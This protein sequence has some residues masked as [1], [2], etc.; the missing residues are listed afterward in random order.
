[1][2][3]TAAA[4]FLAKRMIRKPITAFHNPTADHGRVIVNR[5]RNAMPPALS[6][7]TATNA[8]HNTAAIVAA[9]SKAKSPRRPLSAFFE[10]FCTTAEAVVV[11]SST[12]N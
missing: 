4:G 2:G 12:T 1:M 10:E 6:G 8:S 3:F 5:M 9:T 7:G 11:R